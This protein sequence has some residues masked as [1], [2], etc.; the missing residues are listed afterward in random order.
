MLARARAC[1]AHEGDVS[2]SSSVLE[3]AA[4]GRFR[5]CA[6]GAVEGR[7][8]GDDPADDGTKPQASL[9]ACERKTDSEK[10]D[11]RPPRMSNDASAVGDVGELIFG[12]VHAAQLIFGSSS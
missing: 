8:D 5:E 7:A 12:G 3:T 4:S 2:P 11:G 1:G 10:T 6:D 9:Q